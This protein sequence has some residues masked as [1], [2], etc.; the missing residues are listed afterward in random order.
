MQEG[1]TRAS[2]GQAEKN[3]EMNEIPTRRELLGVGAELGAAFA[4][5]SV[6]NADQV[7]R[8]VWMVEQP[9]RL[10]M[11]T[12]SDLE[13]ITAQHWRLFVKASSMR[14]LLPAVVGHLQTIA[15]FLRS[16]LPTPIEQR[17][18]S[19]VSQQ[20]Q[21][22]GSIYF[23]I[24]HY[25]KA[26][27][28]YKVALQT[29]HRSAHEAIYPVSLARLS[30]LFTYSNQPQDALSHLLA[31]NRSVPQSATVT[32]KVW[33]AVME[34]EA[35]ANLVRATPTTSPASCLK[36]LERAEAVGSQPKTDDDPYGTCFSPADLGA[37]KGVCY[38]RLHQ[39]ENAQGALHVALK[40]TSSF[41]RTAI[42]L[43]ELAEAYVQQGEIEEACKQARQALEITLQTKSLHS[44]Q[45]VETL[46]PQLEGWA[47]TP[48][49]Q[50]LDDWLLMT[51]LRM[52]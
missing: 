31:A 24:H 8:L 2:T 32:T 40:E 43:T 18:S 20:A 22:A 38:L 48:Y 44:L 51:R 5:P 6:L 42:I 30:L 10:D 37:Y 52:T 21:M 36:A 14:D 26:L 15:S 45:R 39:P 35:H 46:R 47:S 13:A 23:D 1:G 25:D 50:D 49:V 29:A 16:S 41:R 7:D 33:L 4:L 3:E 11:E 19:L 17:L 34:A 28:Y 12:L 27:S 9:S